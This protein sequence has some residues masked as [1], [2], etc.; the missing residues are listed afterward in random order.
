MMSDEQSRE[1]EV[2]K[3]YTREKK[4]HN[5]YTTNSAAPQ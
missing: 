4:G 1:N 2:D 3:Y 5:I